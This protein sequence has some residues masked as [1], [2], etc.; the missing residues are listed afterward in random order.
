MRFQ[1]V[2]ASALIVTLLGAAA[3]IWGWGTSNG[4]EAEYPGRAAAFVAGLI[5]AAFGSVIWRSA[6][7]TRRKVERLRDGF[8]LEGRWVIRPE[9]V[10]EFLRFERQRGVANEWRPSRG[11]R[12]SGVQ[13]LWGGETLVVGGVCW[14]IAPGQYPEIDS[15]GLEPGPPPTASIRFRQ[16]WSQRPSS[17]ARLVT[18]MRE[19][20]FPC[21]D[22]AS[23]QAMV[24]RFAGNLAGRAAVDSRKAGR[25]FRALMVLAGLF[26]ASGL[27]GLGFALH[28]G[29]AGLRRPDQARAILIAMT[30][31]GAMGTPAVVAIAVLARRLGSGR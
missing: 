15:V 31:M 6:A 22:I 11:E 3:A 9:A 4:L 29:M 2:R 24:R 14:R 23:G 28:D 20:R 19:F 30:V 1:A 10:A 12:R 5:A 26:A 7:S 27:I 8:G 16:L 13:V 18:T 25:H 17:T 21:T